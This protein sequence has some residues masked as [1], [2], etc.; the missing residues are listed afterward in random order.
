MSKQMMKLENI[1]K[2]IDNL[3][4]D[5]SEIKINIASV[6]E[7]LK[8]LNGTVARHETCIGELYG[9]NKTQNSML[10]KMIG[11]GLLAGAIG[12]TIITVVVGVIF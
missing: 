1:S 5:T 3:K 10:Y 4:D 7:H 11:A 6:R 2:K 9:E 12:G 8:T